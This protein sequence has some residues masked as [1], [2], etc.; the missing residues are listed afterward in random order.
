MA[1]CALA[2][3]D[4]GQI[5]RE[6]FVVQHSNLGPLNDRSESRDVSDFRRQGN[7]L[8]ATQ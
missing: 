1:D 5:G 2:R 7:N 8:N 4:L 3:F 6:S